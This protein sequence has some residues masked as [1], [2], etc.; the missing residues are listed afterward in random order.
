M[1]D[2]SSSSTPRSPAPAAHSEGWLGAQT[3]PSPRHI[4]SPPPT[5]SRCAPPLFSPDFLQHPPSLPRLMCAAHLELPPSNAGRQCPFLRTSLRT[6]G[7]A[8]PKGCPYTSVLQ[9]PVPSH[10]QIPKLQTRLQQTLQGAFSPTAFLQRGDML[11]IT[12]SCQ[13]H[14]TDLLDW[15][16]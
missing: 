5:T 12:P 4:P 6:P 15:N 7:H 8:H 3:P 9:V 14:C 1:Q 16:T 10:P 2:G 11:H 13:T